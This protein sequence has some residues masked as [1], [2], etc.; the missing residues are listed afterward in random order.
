[1]HLEE[2][3]L[4][5]KHNLQDLDEINARILIV[6]NG[7]NPHHP[8]AIKLHMNALRMFLGRKGGY[9]SVELPK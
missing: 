3:K 6:K 8:N 9:F 4:V 2:K 7:S 5:N 1:M